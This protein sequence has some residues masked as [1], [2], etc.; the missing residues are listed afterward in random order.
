[1]LDARD[2]VRGWTSSADV[3]TTKPEPDLVTAAVEKAG[4]GEAVMV[5]DSV[6][7]VESARRVEVETVGVLTG[8]YS[9]AELRA[10]GAVAVFQSLHELR[11][12]L[13]ATPLAGA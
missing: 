8:G 13:D 6:W 9:E 3:G 11:E 12:G 5:G 10:A 7:D 4:G 1:M 2:L